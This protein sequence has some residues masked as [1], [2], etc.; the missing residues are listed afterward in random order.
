MI[1][2]LSSFFNPCLRVRTTSS[3]VRVGSKV[4][5][6]SC[7]NRSIGMNSM[8]YTIELV[9]NS[10]THKMEWK[11]CLI[12]SRVLRPNTSSAK[13]NCPLI[14]TGI[15]MFFPHFHV[16]ISDKSTVVNAQQFGS[17]TDIWSYGSDFLL[18]EHGRC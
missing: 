11:L 13:K 18:V 9:N 2:R 3:C 16:W 5:A 17:G 6:V 10:F 1:H 12:T 8:V 14:V 4:A 7:I 15:K